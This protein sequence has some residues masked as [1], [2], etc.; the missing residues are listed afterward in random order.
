MRKK[1]VDNTRKGIVLIVLSLLMIFASIIGVMAGVSNMAGDLAVEASNTHAD[2]ILAKSNVND[3]TIIKAP[4][5]YYIQEKDECVNI[6]NNKSKELLVA[7][8]F[9]WDSCGYHANAFEK[10]MTD[11]MLNEAHLPIALGGKTLPN[12]GVKGEAFN[13]WFGE[14]E[15]E[16]RAV[17]STLDLKYDT[18]LVNFSYNNDEFYPFGRDRLFTLNLN[19][20]IKIL[21]EGREGFTIIADDDTWVYIDDKIVLDMGGIHKAISGEFVIHDDGEVYSA[22][23]NEDLGYSGVRL[24]KNE[25][26][27]IRIFHA[28]RDSKESVFRLS[29]SNMVFDM[30]DTT[31]AK[32]DEEVAYANPE[33]LEHAKPLGESSTHTPN[34]SRMITASI[35]AQVYAMVVIFLGLGIVI[36]V[37]LRYWRRGR[38]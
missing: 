37:V 22:V 31:L 19:I 26:A 15:G 4:I 5:L 24:V 2:A 38:N 34:K 1:Q 35:T 9:E 20:P 8:Q 10:G 13:R 17:A 33:D 11:P 7:R 36:S 28:N 30:T 18:K 21:S 16:S 3:E 23:G 12:R 25:G 29:F 32:V 27:V 14:K 6:Y